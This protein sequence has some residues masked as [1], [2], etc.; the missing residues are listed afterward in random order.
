VF[1]GAIFTVFLTTMAGVRTVDPQL[2]RTARSF[3]A[4]DRKVFTA[5]VLPATTPF[6]IT[7]LRLGVGLALIGVV[8]GEIFAASSGLGYVIHVTG[9]TLQIDR[10][11]V[12]VLLIAATGLVAAGVLSIAE[13][14]MH[15]WRPGVREV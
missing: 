4:S 6:I 8:I 3:M 12:A 13:R 10:M 1:L 14:R 11:F 2:V 7:G 15:H 5:V 9:S